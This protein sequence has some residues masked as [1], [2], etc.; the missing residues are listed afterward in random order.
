MVVQLGSL[1][2]PKTGSKLQANISKMFRLQ[3]YFHVH[4]LLPAHSSDQKMKD[5][6]Q[7]K[8]SVERCPL[9]MTNLSTI[10]RLRHLFGQNND[11]R[12]R[13]EQSEH[14]LARRRRY[15]SSIE[16]EAQ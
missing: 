2:R 12:K 15:Q 13:A 16:K 14:T 3:R 4:Q 6:H 9:M 7:P 1:L 5:V 8:V 10:L 11:R